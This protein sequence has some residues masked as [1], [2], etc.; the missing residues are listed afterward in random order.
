MNRSRPYVR[1]NFEGLWWR[2][3]GVW[4]GSSWRVDEG[5]FPRDWSE[6]EEDDD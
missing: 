3:A 4:K 6:I 1:E 5:R 2:E